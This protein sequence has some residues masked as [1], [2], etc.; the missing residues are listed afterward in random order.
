MVPYFLSR[1][2][3]LVS[4]AEGVLREVEAS[5]ALRGLL[6]HLVLV[7][8]RETGVY[9]ESEGPRVLRYAQKKTFLPDLICIPTIPEHQSA[10]NCDQKTLTPKMF[11]SALRFTG[12]RQINVNSPFSPLTT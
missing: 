4:L 10:I 11:M 5:L 12:G 7:A 3:I 1:L 2:V 6:A 8:C 9:L